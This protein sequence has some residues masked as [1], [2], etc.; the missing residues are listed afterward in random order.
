[1]AAYFGDP[2]AESG[3][4]LFDRVQG[5]QSRVYSVTER[6]N[7]TAYSATWRDVLERVHA[8]AFKAP[9]RDTHSLA[10]L[11]EDFIASLQELRTRSKTPVGLCHVCWLS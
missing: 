5:M 10:D 4:I 6:L 8:A 1:M 3:H 11:E 2:H 9:L 7:P